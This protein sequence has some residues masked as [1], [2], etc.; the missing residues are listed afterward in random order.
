MNT[1]DLIPGSRYKATCFNGAEV[2][3][4]E[5]VQDFPDGSALVSVSYHNRIYLASNYQLYQG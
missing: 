3:L 5:V 1:T 4:L 2:T